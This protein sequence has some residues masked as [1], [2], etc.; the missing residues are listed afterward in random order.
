VVAKDRTG[1]A[2]AALACLAA[3]ALPAERASAVE[4]LDGRVQIHGYL[5][6]Q[7][8][9]LA[10]GY[11]AADGYDLAQWYNVLNVES[12]WDIAPDGIGPFDLVSAFVRLEARYDC[13]W[14]GACGIPVER[15]YGDQ[16]ARLPRRLADA[17]K[18][19]LVGVTVPGPFADRRPLIQ[20]PVAER[21]AVFG[22]PAGLGLGTPQQHHTGRIWN[23]SGLGEL[24]FAG[25]GPDLLFGTSDD[26]GLYVIDGCNRNPNF[27]EAAPGSAPPGV[28]PPN[29][30]AC[31][32]HRLSTYRFGLQSLPG[33]TNG[34]QT[35]VLGP[36]RPRDGIPGLGFLRKRANPLR[37]GDM[38]PV[39]GLTGQGELPFRPAPRFAF[40]DDGA[41]NDAAR[42]LFLPNAATQRFVGRD[43]FG[44]YDQNM[45]QGELAWN[46]G[47]SQRGERELK[48]A[49]LDLELFESRLWIRGGKQTIVWGKT[50]LFRAQDQFNPQDF[51]LASLPSLEESRTALWSVRGVWSFYDVAFLE[52]VRLELA[53]NLDEFEPVDTGRCGEP[54]A[55][56]VA[57]TR[58]FGFLGQ[59]LAGTGLIGEE[60]PPPF[61]Q[62][63]KGLE[64]G[65]R[66]EF[67]EDRV[68][69]AVTYFRGY[70]DFPHVRPVFVA[71]RNVDPL[72][73]RPRRAGARGRCD[74]DGLVGPPDTSGCLGDF[75]GT[76]QSFSLANPEHVQD[77]LSQH[78]ANQQLF[79]AVCASTLAFTAL[80][81]EGCSLNVWNSTQSAVTDPNDPIFPV[82]PRLSVT[83]SAMLAGGAG[84][85]PQNALF[86]GKALLFSVGEF[87]EQ[88]STVITTP[89]Q[90]PLV[91]LVADPGDGPS[92]SLQDLADAGLAPD[93]IWTTLWG[94]AALAPFL[95]QAQEALLGCGSSEGA[96]P[97][98]SFTRRS[99][100]G[101]HCD[102]TGF[103]LFNTEASAFFQSW[104]GFEGTEGG[105]WLTNDA[106]RAQPGTTGFAGGP[107]C[108]RFEGSLLVLPGCT[109]GGG[110]VH[111]FTGQVFQSEMA[112][113]SWNAL[114][115]FV[116]LSLP[117]DRNRDGVADRPQPGDRFFPYRFDEFDPLDPFRTDGCSY[118]NPS[119][120]KNVANLLT[121]TAVEKRTVKAGG[122][123]RF[124]RRDFQWAGGASAVLDYQRRHVFGFAMDF[125]EDLSK[126]SWGVEFTW[127]PKVLVVDHDDFDA[128]AE[129][130]FYNLVISVDRLTFIN[131]LNRSRTFFMNLQVFLQLAEEHRT[132]FPRDGPLNALATFTILTGYHQDRLI[133]SFTWVHDIQSRSGGGLFGLTYRYTENL[134]IQVGANAFYGEVHSL[135]AALVAPGPPA[136]GAGGGSQHA[137]VE[138]GLSQIRDRDEF[139]LRLRYTF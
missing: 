48:E 120:C 70:D 5:E 110:L 62:D 91:P 45:S 14:S 82:A 131:F 128:L 72:T 74:P 42:G 30:V 18:S 33:P 83:F 54:Y 130:D 38:Q 133:P 49:Y 100:W 86:N 19:G 22:A 79:H 73:G 31:P 59:A 109:G 17:R 35:R 136:G 43:H 103:D 32:G 10:D 85:Q 2:R 50:E 41:P 20:I 39:L 97:E 138:N 137:Y 7:V 104:P 71:E 23:V 107:V 89:A 34:I 37:P 29:D 25:R 8:R 15:V 88:G 98:L 108:T 63:E 123:G 53:A 134:S 101:T 76:T 135:E 36:W 9:V 1:R 112:A 27:P 124:G 96:T 65:A 127:F 55:P 64:W 3:L 4:F 46:H 28:A 111:P 11:S 84:T 75:D 113:L 139:F 93:P 87:A 69:F 92:L 125:A 57:C 118:R 60:R 115:L 129:V 119:V 78:S 121:L 122:N 40:D 102:I 26:P 58:S 114:M 94:T 44:F 99:Y 56:P 6:E 116:T 132:S 106:S 61:W 95:N 68:S 52:D 67:R 13:V 90:L 126:T 21:Q 24:F 80:L 77:V 47:A 51:G 16:A 105:V 66:L 117:D 12:E 81:P